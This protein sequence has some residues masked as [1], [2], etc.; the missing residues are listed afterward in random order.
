[1]ASEASGPSTPL[2]LPLPGRQ[3]LRGHHGVDL[4]LRDH[5]AC[6]ACAA[7]DQALTTSWYRY[8]SRLASFPCR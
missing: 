7:I 4:C 2:A 3:E 8:T 6:D 5:S 1:M